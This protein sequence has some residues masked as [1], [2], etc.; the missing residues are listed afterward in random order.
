MTIGKSKFII[1]GL[2]LTLSLFAITTNVMADPGKG[3][4]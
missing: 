1:F 3:K 4:Q 2:A